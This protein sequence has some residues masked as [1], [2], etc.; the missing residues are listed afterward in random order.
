[1]SPSNKTLTANQKR[2]LRHLW[3]GELT[4]QEIAEEMGFTA[5][6]LQEAASFLGLPSRID[7]DV[8]IPT[9]LEIKAATAEIRAKWTPAEREARLVAAWSVRIATGEHNG[10]PGRNQSSD[11]DEGGS[12]DACPRRK[13]RRGRGLGV[14]SEH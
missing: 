13:R 6:E 5:E 1:M 10:D 9:Q 11:L 12:S 4:T 3:K 7:P 14:Q 8:Y 2:Q